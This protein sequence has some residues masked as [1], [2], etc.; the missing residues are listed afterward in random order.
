MI[1]VEK[2]SCRFFT[3]FFPAFYCATRA[4]CGLTQPAEKTQGYMTL[5]FACSV[6]VI[7]NNEQKLGNRVTH[8]KLDT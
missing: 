4:V 5:T 6:C 1:F 8:G 7:E 2:K 3:T